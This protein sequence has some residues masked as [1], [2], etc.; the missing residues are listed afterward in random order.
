MGKW[1][2][3]LV[4][5]LALAACTSGVDAPDASPVSAAESTRADTAASAPQ[6]TDPTITDPPEATTAPTTGG[7]GCV[8]FEGEPF[9][10]SPV[11]EVSDLPGSDLEVRAVE[12]PHPGYEGN[13]WSEWGQ[14][15]V[16][17]N[18]RYYSAIGDHLG[19]EGNSYIYEFDPA[20]GTLTQIADVAS[21]VRTNSNDWGHGKI[22]AQ[23]VAGP[24]GELYATT[25]W[26]SR[27]GIESVDYSGGLLLRIDPATRTV[28]N[29]GAPVPGHGIPS[30]ASWPE[31]GLL[32]GEAADPL[33]P[34]GT[35]AGPFFVYDTTSGEVIF[36]D[37]DA[38]HR[39]YRS[40]AVGPDGKAYVTFGEG[41]LSVYDPEANGFVDS[42]SI[43]G[44]RL[45]AATRPAPDG[46]IYAASDRPDAFFSIRVDGSVTELGTPEGYTASMVFDEENGAVYSMPGAHGDGYSFGTPLV[47]LDLGTGSQSDVVELAPLVE[48]AM[49]LRAGGTYGIAI[50]E[51]AGKI[52]MALNA[53]GPT[54]RDTFGH[55]VLV[56]VTLP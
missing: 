47:A 10:E 33:Q 15:I 14:G 12:Y 35:N 32:Y 36:S 19:A 44:G 30:L 25:Y 17:A 40:I 27:R 13:P 7:A 52:F 53:G 43:P 38:S 37:D 50:D 42:V 54:N 34:T 18:G 39:G 26:G 5:A 21:L 6:T 49:G 41:S 46:T 11:V 28:A 20:A 3:G 56:E 29:L 9:Q 22:H 48:D 31:G 23:I 2:K 55:V 8:P 16:A 51:A 1:A 4:V 24:C 45:R